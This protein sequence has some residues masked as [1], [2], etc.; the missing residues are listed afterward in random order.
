MFVA[1]LLASSLIPGHLGSQRFDHL[2]GE[3]VPIQEY[4]SYMFECLPNGTA[5]LSG[6]SQ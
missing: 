2:N 1:I 4:V 5:T 3:A 6:P